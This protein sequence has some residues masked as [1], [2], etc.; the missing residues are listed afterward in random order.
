MSQAG[1]FDHNFSG[2]DESKIDHRPWKIKA[3]VDSK[4]C[5]FCSGT[6]LV[7]TRETCTFMSAYE[8]IRCETCH[9]AGP[10][11]GFDDEWDHEYTWNHRGGVK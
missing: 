9:A 1:A 3:P 7:A 6:D 2:I 4:S 8:C 10:S 5:P 11:K